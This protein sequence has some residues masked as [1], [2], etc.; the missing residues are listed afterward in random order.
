VPGAKY[1]HWRGQW[2]EGRMK[3]LE[4]RVE[5]VPYRHVNNWILH[6][7]CP[8]TRNSKYEIRNKYKLLKYK[9][10]KEASNPEAEY[11]ILVSV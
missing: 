5:K 7:G 3:N 4:C 10:S 9:G 6:A 1:N 2:L 11:S 8:E